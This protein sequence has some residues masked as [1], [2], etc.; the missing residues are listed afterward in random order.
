M[1]AAGERRFRM[2]RSLVERSCARAMK[3]RDVSRIRG[4]YA[5]PAES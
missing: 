4:H 1:I 3:Y 2:R 5:D